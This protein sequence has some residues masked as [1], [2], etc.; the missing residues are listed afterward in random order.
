MAVGDVVTLKSDTTQ[1][2]TVI[3]VDA[4]DGEIKCSYL[5]AG[6]YKKV[7]FPEDALTPA[8]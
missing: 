3:D 1:K 2:L 8:V 6:E 7:Q 4:E 5:F